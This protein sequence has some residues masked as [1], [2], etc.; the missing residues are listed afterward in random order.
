MAQSLN[1]EIVVQTLLSG[2]NHAER[3]DVAVLKL[4]SASRSLETVVCSH[5]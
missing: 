1:F 4:K 3:A 5:N 2:A